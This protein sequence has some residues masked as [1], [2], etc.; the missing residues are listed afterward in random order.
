MKKKIILIAGAVAIAAFCYV[1][2]Y[3]LRPWVRRYYFQGRSKVTDAAKLRPQPVGNIQAA[4]QC[5]ANLRA[6]E[7][8]KRKVAQE[9]GKAF[10]R[11]TWDDLRPEF[12]GGRIP[13][14]P[15]GGE[16]ILN[17]IGMMP[18]CTIGSNG[19]VYREDDHLVINY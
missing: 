18:K 2:W 19:T 1:N 9:K 4:Q 13:K 10:G 14:C 17:D 16:Y 3:W 8:A 12:P 6:I 7:N 5:R 15:A 11:L